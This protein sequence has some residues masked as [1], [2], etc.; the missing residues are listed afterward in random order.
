MGVLHVTV[1]DDKLA[2]GTC[3]VIAAGSTLTLNDLT[4]ERS[5]PSSSYSV[6]RFSAT[7]AERAF[8]VRANGDLLAVPTAAPA[9]PAPFEQ[10]LGSIPH[11]EGG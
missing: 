4:F 1:R 2:Q 8:V 7:F 6:F 9:D 5:P 11:R 3:T 10:A